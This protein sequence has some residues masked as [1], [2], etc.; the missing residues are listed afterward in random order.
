MS[1]DA[2]LEHWRRREQFVA[3]LIHDMITDS[4]AEAF[5]MNMIEKGVRAYDIAIKP[6]PTKEPT[7]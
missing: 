2:A 6:P 3:R 1:E 5:T 4:N 7:P